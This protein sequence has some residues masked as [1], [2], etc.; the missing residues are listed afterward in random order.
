MAELGRQIENRFGL[1]VDPKT[2]YR[3]ADVLPIQRADLEIAG[4]VA[5]ILDV[6]LDDLFD[7][8]AVPI[9]QEMASDI[10]VLDAQQSRRLSELFDS[11]A[12]GVLSP[13]HEEEL[14]ALVG[15]YGR[16]LRERRLRELAAR[17]GISIEDATRESDD[18]LDR[19]IAWWRSF[20]ASPERRRAVVAQAKKRGRRS[21]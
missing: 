9:A 17:R 12:R 18:D 1:T 16:Q 3:L 11:Q 8:R 2:L 14:E 7:V 6:G 5:R 13:A 15:T 4:A 21:T 10:D 20:E 19:A